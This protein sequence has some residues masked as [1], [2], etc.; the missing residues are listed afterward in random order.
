MK[1]R[2]SYCNKGLNASVDVSKR[3]YLSMAWTVE[4]A[5]PTKEKKFACAVVG[6]VE[7]LIARVPCPREKRMTYYDRVTIQRREGLAWGTKRTVRY[8]GLFPPAMAVSGKCLYLLWCNHFLYYRIT[9]CMVAEDYGGGVPHRMIHTPVAERHTESCGFAGVGDS[10]YILRSPTPLQGGRK[11]PAITVDAFHIPTGTWRRRAPAPFGRM[12]LQTAAVSVGTVIYVVGGT[13]TGITRNR[14]IYAYDTVTNVWTDTQQTPF[15][16]GIASVAVHNRTIYMNGIA[17]CRKRGVSAD[18]VRAF[19]TRT[20]TLTD[21]PFEPYPLRRLHFT[22][23]YD[24]L[25]AMDSHGV[26]HTRQLPAAY[27]WTPTTHKHFPR[28]YRRIVEALM[29]CIARS[30][31]LPVDVVPLILACVPIFANPT[32]RVQTT[33]RPRQKMLPHFFRDA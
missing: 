19:D 16:E 24:T 2:D 32:A 14:R 29:L 12:N 20:T 21:L 4:T 10:L 3:R 27:L 6:N 8:E 1:L 30:D 13:P 25:I 9:E 23:V 11:L 31:V 28:A 5:T 22:V 26:R 18:C 33:R 15:E 7:Y 17:R